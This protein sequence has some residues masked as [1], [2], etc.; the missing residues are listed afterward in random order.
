[1]DKAYIYLDAIFDRYWEPSAYVDKAE[2]GRTLQLVRLCIRELIGVIAS[3]GLT[4]RLKKYDLSDDLARIAT[5]VAAVDLALAIMLDYDYGTLD[6][7]LHEDEMWEMA[8]EAKDTEGF[9]NFDS[10]VGELKR[11]VLEK[12]DWKGC[13]EAL[14][15]EK[16]VFTTMV[17][18]E[19]KY[20]PSLQKFDAMLASRKSARPA[21]RSV[22]AVAEATARLANMSESERS[23]LFSRWA[24]EEEKEKHEDPGRFFID[25]AGWISRHEYEDGAFSAKKKYKLASATERKLLKKKWGPFGGVASTSYKGRSARYL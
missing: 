8:E 12:T 2:K 10:A 7:N 15:L 17:Q 4:E 22:G 1:M 25:D 6:E 21:R 23:L 16:G 9:E 3:L 14:L 18:G 13:P 20:V 11:V 24:K 19:L 5:T